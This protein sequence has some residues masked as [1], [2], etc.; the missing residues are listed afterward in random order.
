MKMLTIL[1]KHVQIKAN[2]LYDGDLAEFE[3]EISNF[4]KKNHEDHMHDGLQNIISH[5]YLVLK[6]TT[7]Y[8]K[9]EVMHISPPS[10]N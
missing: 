4:R 6:R 2:H 5:S 7:S 8:T 10:H 3:P 1:F 9:R